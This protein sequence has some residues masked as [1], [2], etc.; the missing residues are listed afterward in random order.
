MM[1]EIGLERTNRRRVDTWEIAGGL[2][3]KGRSKRRHPAT[4]FYLR[5]LSCRLSVRL[6]KNTRLA[7]ALRSIGFLSPAST[8]YFLD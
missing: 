6:G 1:R 8:V 2:E 4:V 3:K 7:R 5:L